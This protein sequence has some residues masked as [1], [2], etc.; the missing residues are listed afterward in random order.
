MSRGS[1]EWLILRNPAGVEVRVAAQNPV[2]TVLVERVRRLVHYREITKLGDGGPVV[3]YLAS[4]YGG[5]NYVLAAP[6]R[7]NL[8]GM[9][10]RDAKFGPITVA[11]WSGRSGSECFRM[12]IDKEGGMVVRY[13]GEFGG[14]GILDRGTGEMTPRQDGA[15]KEMVVQS[16]WRLDE[17]TQQLL[18]EQATRA[19][20]R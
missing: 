9:V 17:S 1:R 11:M 20:G 18:L 2:S 14:V 16:Y 4:Q 7:M 13:N 5:E 10:T 8:V 6:V 3:A 15:Y 19:C 12:E